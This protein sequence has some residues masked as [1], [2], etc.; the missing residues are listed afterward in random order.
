M[1]WINIDLIHHPFIYIFNPVFPFKHCK[2]K[3][4]NSFEIPAC[5][6]SRLTFRLIR[7]SIRSWHKLTRLMHRTK[8]NPPPISMNPLFTLS[9]L[10]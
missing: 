6:L 4:T 5:L 3:P 9:L 2:N 7:K 1:N 8:C 10:T